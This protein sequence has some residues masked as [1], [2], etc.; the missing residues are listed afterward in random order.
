MPSAGAWDV[1]YGATDKFLA[2]VG[3]ATVAAK[4]VDGIT[5]SSVTALPGNSQNSDQNVPRQVGSTWLINSSV[6][7]TAYLSTDYGASW[8]TETLPAVN[9]SNGFYVVNGLFFFWSSATTAYTSATGVTGSWTA[10]TLPANGSGDVFHQ[11]PDGSITYNDGL[12][13]THRTT[14]GI[15]WSIVST[16]SRSGISRP[17]LYLPS[18]VIAE[19]SNTANNCFT[20]HNGVRILRDANVVVNNGPRL[21]YDG[22]NIILI[23]VG[24]SLVIKLTDAL[25]NAVF[26]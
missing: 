4:S 5:W 23:G 15:N 3:G 6:A 12:G 1:G 26:R 8:S 10:R 22:S 11:N 19:I 18:G 7:S 14:D 24:G 21:A 2:T 20:I 16:L 9:G 25:P 17:S 13:N